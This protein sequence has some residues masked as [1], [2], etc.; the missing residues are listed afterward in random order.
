[1]AMIAKDDLLFVTGANVDDDHPHGDID[2]IDYSLGRLG[3]RDKDAVLAGVDVVYLLECY[4]MRHAGVGTSD[5]SKTF[6]RYLDREAIRFIVECFNA[7]WGDVWASRNSNH[8]DFYNCERHGVG[9]NED[10]H[11]AFS[12]YFWKSDTHFTVDLDEA[13]PTVGSVRKRPLLSLQNLRKLYQGLEYYRTFR[14]GLYG[15]PAYW[16]CSVS[17]T[18][19]EG[20]IVSSDG[21]VLSPNLNEYGGAGRFSDEEFC[22]KWDAEKKKWRGYHVSGFAKQ[23]AT[24]T[25]DLKASMPAALLKC[26]AKVKLAYHVYTS[27]WYYGDFGDGADVVNVLDSKYSWVTGSTWY[28]PSSDGTVTV[29]PVKDAVLRSKCGVKDHANWPSGAPTNADFLSG[30]SRCSVHR[31]SKINDGLNF[32]LVLLLRLKDE[33]CYSG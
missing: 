28:T 7:L 15:A 24:M 22:A 32:G 12:D 30:S 6:Y 13:W 14:W 4:A 10:F 21:E 2:R 25:I 29:Y 33:Y 9:H 18:Q 26:V 16:T 20:G 31:V 11:Q 8:D 17:V 1:M 23:S 19:I 27:I 3:E 5:V